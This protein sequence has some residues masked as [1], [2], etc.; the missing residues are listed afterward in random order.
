MNEILT[1]SELEYARTC[2]DQLYYQ[3]YKSF[4]DYLKV[5]KDNKK[6]RGTIY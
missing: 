4:E 3:A 2:F 6:I 5:V 1:K